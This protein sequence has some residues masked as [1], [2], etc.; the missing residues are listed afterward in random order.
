[1]S[2]DNIAEQSFDASAQNIQQNLSNFYLKYQGKTGM[3]VT[4][5]N[6]NN[7]SRFFHQSG[8][9]T[10]VDLDFLYLD[11]GQSLVRIRLS[12]IVSIA[13]DNRRHLND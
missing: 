6:W 12:N 13:P 11:T 9:I 4:Q 10:L 7:P 8:T 3:T 2:R 5:R 1:M